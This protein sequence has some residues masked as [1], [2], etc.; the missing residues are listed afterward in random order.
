MGS[1]DV[2]TSL[3]ALPACLILTS[4]SGTER[5]TRSSGIR[6]ESTN[7]TTLGRVIADESLM[8]QICPVTPKTSYETTALSIV[9]MVGSEV[10]MFNT[11]ESHLAP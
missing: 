10:V 3:G 2:L 1:L 7:Q 5:E 11:F 4:S 9:M 8:K 6:L